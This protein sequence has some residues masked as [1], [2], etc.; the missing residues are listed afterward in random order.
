MCFP[1]L[2]QD[3]LVQRLPGGAL[4][5]LDPRRHTRASLAGLSTTAPGLE[6]T[7]ECTMG[8]VDD[9]RRHRFARDVLAHRLT[10]CGDGLV[11]EGLLG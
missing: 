5:P 1:N 2:A 10:C 8:L 7:L 9:A 4:R 3:R 11:D 6:H